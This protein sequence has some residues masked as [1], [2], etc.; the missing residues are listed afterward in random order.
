MSHIPRIGALAV[1]LHDQKVLLVRRRKQPDAGL[2]GYPGGHVEF[3][4]T[5]AEAAVRELAEE[6]GLTATPGRHLLNLDLILRD[7]AGAAQVHYLL[8]AVQCHPTGGTLA[9]ADDAL[10]AQWFAFDDVLDARAPLSA[11][12]DT[13]LRLA[14][15]TG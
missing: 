3:G 9:A 14:L 15:G 7:A 2:W 4:E 8:V 1:V 12:V 11:N 13:V 5:V 6:T 10:D